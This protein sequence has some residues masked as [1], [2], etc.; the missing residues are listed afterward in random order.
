MTEP[1]IFTYHEWRTF[2]SDWF[3]YKRKMDPDFSLRKFSQKAKVSPGY[4]PLILNRSRKFSKKALNNILPNLGLSA[5]EQSYFRLLCKFGTDEDHQTRIDALKKIQR[6][7]KYEKSNPRE[8]EIYDYMSNWLNVAI[9]EMSHVN[10]FRAEPDWIYEQLRHKRSLRDIRKSLQFLEAQG[11]LTI[12]KD[13]SVKTNNKEIRCMD[14]VF[15]TVLVRFH[16]EMLKLAAESVDKSSREERL[17]TGYTMAIKKER[18]SEIEKILGE[19]LAKIKQLE[20]KSENADAVYHVA[21]TSFPLTN[22]ISKGPIGR[23]IA[24]R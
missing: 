6:F 8:F 4:L 3:E 7:N 10:A 19:A 23:K 16:R 21:L 14:R 13:K 11:F 24:I 1:N 5:V 9:Q 20:A 2:L 17:V 18:Y 12:N 22:Q 15:S